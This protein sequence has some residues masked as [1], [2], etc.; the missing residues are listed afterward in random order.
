MLQ[1]CGSQRFPVVHEPGIDFVISVCI[2][3][4]IIIDGIHLPGT[5]NLQLVL[6]STSQLPPVL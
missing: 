2:Q 3:V 4:E 5:N 1:F 6:N